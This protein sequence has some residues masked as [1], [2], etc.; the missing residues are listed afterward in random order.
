[1]ELEPIIT[2]DDLITESDPILV[3]LEPIITDGD[4]ITAHVIFE[5]DDK[6]WTLMRTLESFKVSIV[7]MQYHVDC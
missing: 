5:A 6:P 2:D 1:M 7:Y 4:P 3:E